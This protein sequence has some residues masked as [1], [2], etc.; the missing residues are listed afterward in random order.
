MADLVIVELA[1]I[2]PHRV[3][4]VGGEKL[5][6]IELDVD[7]GEACLTYDG[8]GSMKRFV[9]RENIAWWVAM[10]GDGVFGNG[11]EL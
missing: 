9:L 3:F 11:S 7:T 5:K 6:S 4:K 2:S 10:E 8:L 1:I